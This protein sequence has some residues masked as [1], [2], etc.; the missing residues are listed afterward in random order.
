M[1]AR[2]D[3]PR[4]L[5]L[6]AAWLSLASSAIATEP[7][8][9]TS[10]EGASFSQGAISSPQHEDRR[11]GGLIFETILKAVEREPQRTSGEFTENAV[12][13]AATDAESLAAAT[14][15]QR[16]TEAQDIFMHYLSTLLHH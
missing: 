5:L 8:L 4:K 10:T 9:E 16:Q 12:F 3:R 1:R 2:Q 14:E 6:F 7:S 13:G 11:I 15:T